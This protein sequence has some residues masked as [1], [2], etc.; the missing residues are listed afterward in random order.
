LSGRLRQP[1]PR[2]SG[3]AFHHSNRSAA[4]ISHAT[5]IVFDMLNMRLEDRGFVITQTVHTLQPFESSD[6]LFLYLLGVDGGLYPVHRL[7]G[8][9]GDTARDVAW[10]SDIQSKLMEAMQV[11]S[12][13]RP[14]DLYNY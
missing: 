2:L 1:H 3:P 7:P 11:S 10:P 6:N 5:V 13:Q 12:R 14:L 9:E 8:T 4:A